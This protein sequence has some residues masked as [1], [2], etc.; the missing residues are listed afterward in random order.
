MAR[1]K[2]DLERAEDAITFL[3]PNDR[4]NWVKMAFAVKSEFGED[5]FNL[6][7]EWS[8]SGEGYRS[9][10]ALATW[11]TAKAGGKVGIGTLFF[12]AKERG[13]KDDSVRKHVSAE[14]KARRAAEVARRDAEEAAEL[15]AQHAAARDRAALVWGAATECT[16]HPYLTRKGVHSHGLRVGVWEVLDEDTGEWRTISKNALLVP[17]RDATKQIHSLQAIFPA[18]VGPRD[19]DYLKGGAKSGHFYSFGKPVT[20]DVAGVP[21]KIIMIGEGY[22]TMASAHELVTIQSAWALTAAL[23]LA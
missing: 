21:R 17:I 20:M 16:E 22:A 23:V 18:K 1:E 8:Q 19:K 10:D 14:E 13:W 4:E 2:T 12:Q 5:G 7:D 11:K 3:D 6:W 9:K 15:A